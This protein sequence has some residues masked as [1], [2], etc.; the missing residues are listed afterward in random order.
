MSKLSLGCYVDAY[1]GGLWGVED[2]NDP[3][4]SKPRNGYILLLDNCLIL[5]VSKLQTLISFSTLEYEYVS[6]SESLIDILP[7]RSFLKELDQY[8]HFGKEMACNT[9]STV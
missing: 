3:I 4:S 1:F 6:L 5:L 8:L 2:A 7:L 9:H